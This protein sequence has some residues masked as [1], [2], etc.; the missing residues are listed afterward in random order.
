MKTATALEFV[1]ALLLEHEMEIQF[2]WTAYLDETSPRTSI[3]RANRR[4]A[5]CYALLSAF[6]HALSTGASQDIT[7]AKWQ[8][9]RAVLVGVASARA[10]EGSTALHTA[11]FIL[12]MKLA[13]FDVLNREFAGK[14]DLREL[15]SWAMSTLVDSLAL[16]LLEALQRDRDRI[17]ARQRTELLE[18][19][20][21]VRVLWDSNLALPLI[22]MLDSERAQVIME[23]VLQK[24]ADIGHWLRSSTS[25][26]YLR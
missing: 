12:S 4:W 19:S 8:E 1:G 16:H 7:Q 14:P 21:P 9:T 13:M 5:Q 25:P 23:S 18:L 20:T 17:I 22:G 6:I 24:I 10:Q 26:A 15:G 11:S 2:G 3:E